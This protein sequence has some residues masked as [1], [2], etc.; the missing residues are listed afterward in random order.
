MFCGIFLRDS[1]KSGRIVRWVKRANIRPWRRMKAEAH[2]HVYVCS[3]AMGHEQCFFR[4]S[5][6]SD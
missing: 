6:A 3:R 2:R 4:G 5:H 1:R